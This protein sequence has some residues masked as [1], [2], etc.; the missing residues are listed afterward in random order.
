MCSTGPGDDRVVCR[1]EPFHVESATFTDKTL[2]PVPNHCTTDLSTCRDTDSC[3]GSGTV[4][5]DD[6]EIAD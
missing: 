3:T 5:P 4:E 1:F 6:N 2:D